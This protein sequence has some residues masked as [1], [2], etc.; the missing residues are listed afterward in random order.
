MKKQIKGEWIPG[1]DLLAEWKIT[2]F[3]LVEYIRTGLHPYDKRGAPIQ[4]PTIWKVIEFLNISNPK[5]D[6]SIIKICSLLPTKYDDFF[7]PSEEQQKTFA[8]CELELRK[9]WTIQHIPDFLFRVKDV[10]DFEAEHGL[11]TQEQKT[12]SDAAPKTRVNER[13]A[14]ALEFAKQVKKNH[15]NITGNEAAKQ[16]NLWLAKEYKA[17]SNIAKGYHEKYLMKLIRHLG[18]KPGKP[19]RIPKK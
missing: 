18:F 8:R 4:K 17:K 1:P 12:Q 15:P 2:D 19:G 6:V 14:L 13:L 10:S 16:I 5:T 3:E 9:E 7:H 11:R